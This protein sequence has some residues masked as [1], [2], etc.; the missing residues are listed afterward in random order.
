MN[1]I[2]YIEMLGSNYK[3]YIDHK[4]GEGAWGTVYLGQDIRNGE[5]VA[6]KTEQIKENKEQLL[7]TEFA[8]LNHAHSKN[9]TQKC[10]L[11]PLWYGTKDKTNYLV[12]NLLGTSLNTMLKKC[13]GHFSMKT[14]LMLGIQLIERIK[15][16]HDGDIIHRDIK[17][18]NFLV[19]YSVSQKNIY[20]IDF[21]FAKKYRHGKKHIPNKKC[22]RRLGTA[23]FMSV[24]SHEKNEQC[25]IDDMYSIGYM[26]LTFMIGKLEWSGIKEKEKRK[27]YNKI[28]D[29]KKQTTNEKLVENVSCED[30]RISELVCSAKHNLKSYFDYLDQCEFG[31]IIDY[32]YLI[33]LF[34]N[35]MY[36]HEYINDS[37]WDWLTI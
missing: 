16:Y 26:I 2:N 21:G 27:R 12:T 35:S 23:R 34:K 24:N 22:N 25:C 1:I 17:P 8:L 11:K 19:D 14:S 3:I 18:S 33:G 10:V 28:Y 13:F 7:K 37:K 32:E 4:I 31:D 15:Y 5:L 6:I 30:C 36:N 9:N 20:L 29:I